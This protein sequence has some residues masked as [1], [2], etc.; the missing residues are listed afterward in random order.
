VRDAHNHPVHS[1]SQLGPGARLSVEFADGRVAATADA[2]RPATASVAAKPVGG[3]P[4][5]A[6]ARRITKPVDQGS[7]F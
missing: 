6:A 7:L 5:P 4:K 1:A 2:D 3:E